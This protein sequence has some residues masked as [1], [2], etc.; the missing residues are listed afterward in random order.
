MNKNDQLTVCFFGTYDRDYTSNKLILRGLHENNGKVVE[1]N[2]HTPVTRLDKKEEMNIFNLVGRVLK[3]Y[4]LFSEI[5]KHWQEIKAS[6]VIY[7]GYPGHF[8]VI[9]A[10]I[11]SKLTGVKMVFNPLLIFYTGFTEEQR[12]LSKNSFLGKVIKAGETFIY[13]LCDLVFADTP[14][15]YEYLKND[16][17]V[18]ESKLR[19]LPIGADN[20][21]YSYTPYF[22]NEKT[23]NVVY[24]GLYSPIHG[25][26]HIIEAARLLKDDKDVH[27]TM[28]GIGQTFEKNYKRAQKL[29]LQNITFHHNVPMS[30]HPA[31]IQKADIFLGFLQKHPSVD[32]IIPNKIYQGLALGRTIVTADAPVIRSLFT[33]KK[34]MYTCEA[35]NPQSFVD[36]IID[37][38]NNPKMRSEI[39]INGYNLF[40]NEFT[41]KAVGAKLLAFIRE[42][43]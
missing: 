41:P 21:Y 8:D 4:R 10:Y 30:E 6:D 38:K 34:N 13:N 15:Q 27:F 18:K 25:V 1:V 29:G 43:L 37:L 2:A 17:H 33:N 23:V 35:A 36:A 32:R 9:F 31:I 12:I 16:F 22:N 7:V 19:V 20:T 14:F 5:A 39:A 28:V 11:V 3:K 42:I 26:E 40:M 24:Y